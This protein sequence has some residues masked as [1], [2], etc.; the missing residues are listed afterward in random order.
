MHNLGQT[1]GYVCSC[2]MLSAFGRFE[3]VSLPSTKEIFI[4][5]RSNHYEHSLRKHRS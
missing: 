3:M 2:F 4:K 5:E 1:A